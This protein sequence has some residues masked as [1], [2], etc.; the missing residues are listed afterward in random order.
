MLDVVT[1][2]I[3]EVM[4]AHR[5]YEYYFSAKALTLATIFLLGFTLFFS[6]LFI[7]TYKDDLLIAIIF[8]LPL[9]VILPI[10][11]PDYVRFM[12]CAVTNRPAVILSPDGLI[13]NINGRTYKWSEIKEIKYVPFS[14]MNAPPG[15]YTSL[16]L[17]AADKEIRLGHNS[18]K[19]KTTEFLQ[20][21]IKYHKENRHG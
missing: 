8:S 16:T 3:S 2:S 21:L 4:K 13:N 19:C 11:L 5:K 10:A 1:N 14:G 20:T 17:M 18:I 7:K 15:G 6:V 9:I 12:F